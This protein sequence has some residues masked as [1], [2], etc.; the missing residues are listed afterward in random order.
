MRLEWSGHGKNKKCDRIFQWEYEKRWELHG[1]RE[2]DQILGT[3]KKCVLWT[4]Y[5]NTKV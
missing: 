5:A 3:H 1:I 2:G 4:N